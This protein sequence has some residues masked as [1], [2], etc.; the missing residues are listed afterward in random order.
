MKEVHPFGNYFPPKAERLIVGSFPIG[1]FTHPKRKS[2]I[3]THEYNFH[4]GGETNLLWKLLARVFDVE[5]KRTEEIK[6]FLN[7]NKIG[8]ADLIV[9]CRRKNGGASDSDLYDI[10]W[11]VELP[12]LI[13]QHRIKMIY[14]TSKYVQKKFHRLFPEV[15]VPSVLL[16][17]PSA[18]SYRSLGRDAGYAKFKRLHPDL[19]AFDY[20]LMCY[21]KAFGS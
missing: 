9:S 18:Q 5:F 20:I 16:I 3:K 13:V 12:N 11:N 6:K 19:K 14:F 4:F 15:T 8:L 7:K 1:K 17:S 10:T 21:R 2:E